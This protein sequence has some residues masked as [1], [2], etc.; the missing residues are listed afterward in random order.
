LSSGSWAFQ[1]LYTFTE[2]AQENGGP[3]GSNLIF[4]RSGTIYGTTYYDGPSGAGSVF[5]LTPSMG[6]Y[7]YTALHNFCVGDE[8]CPDGAL[9][10][11]TLVMDSSGNLYG[12]TQQGGS[13][14]G[15]CNTGESYG[16]CGVIFKITP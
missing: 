8:A 6:G 1:L 7:I 5:K 12:T 3:E 15:V 2:V 10:S 13:N 16:A 4:D 14:S 11:G 9:P